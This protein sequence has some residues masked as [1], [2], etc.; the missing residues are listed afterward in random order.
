[1]SVFTNSILTWHFYWHSL[2]STTGPIFLTMNTPHLEKKNDLNG[3]GMAT[4]TSNWLKLEGTKSFF[5]FYISCMSSILVRASILYG[6]MIKIIKRWETGY[7]KIYLYT[8]WDQVLRKKIVN[9]KKINYVNVV[10]QNGKWKM[11]LCDKANA[12]PEIMIPQW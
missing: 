6:R 8:T 7:Q 3:M 2:H 9:R 11:Y 5:T 12:S 10:F 1:M 4:T